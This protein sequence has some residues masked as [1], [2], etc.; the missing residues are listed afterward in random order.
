MEKWLTTIC[1]QEAAAMGALGARIKIHSSIY[2]RTSARQV[3]FMVSTQSADRK[4]QFGKIRLMA[5]DGS[6][7]K[8]DPS[9]PYLCIRRSYANRDARIA[10]QKDGTFFRLVRIPQTSIWQYTPSDTGLPGVQGATAIVRTQDAILSDALSTAG[11]PILRITGSGRHHEYT[12]A[13][14]LPPQP[15]IEASPLTA[16][17]LIEQW[18]K[19]PDSVPFTTVFGQAARGLT[20]RDQLHR[21]VSRAIDSVIVSKPGTKSHAIIRTDATGKAWDTAAKFFS[22]IR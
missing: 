13:A 5:N 1:T 16:A 20:I 6:L 2:Q 12:H 18:R 15:G 7:Q 4:W 8:K 14:I 3:R 19:D 9:H 10:M 22:G 11:Y 21:E 17:D